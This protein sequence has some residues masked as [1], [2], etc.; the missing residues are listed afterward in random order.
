MTE[1]VPRG[2]LYDVLRKTDPKRLTWRRRVEIAIGTSLGMHFLHTQGVAHMDLKSL[3]VLIGTDFTPKICD[4]GLCREGMISTNNVEGLGSEDGT[5]GEE[6]QPM[7]TFEWMAPEVMRCE[8]PRRSAD[9]YSF[10]VMLWELCA[11]DTPYR[12][13]R[14]KRLLVHLVGD[15]GMRP[16]IPASCEDL[17]CGLMV[18]CWMGVPS[19][20]PSFQAVVAELREMRK[21]DM[22]GWA[23]Q[24]PVETDQQDHLFGGAS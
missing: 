2:S 7:G 4:F 17:W 5:G 24:P 21:V 6:E 8:A 14:N 3:N 9:V 20:R 13:V 12:S 15:E 11:L 1:F 16:P 18:R 19:E 22:T 23:V 10:G